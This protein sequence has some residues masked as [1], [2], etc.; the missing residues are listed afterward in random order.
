MGC[1]RRDFTQPCLMPTS[2][3]YGDNF[4]VPTEAPKARSGGTLFQQL[5]GKSLKKGPSTSLGTTGSG[6]SPGR[7][8]M[9]TSSL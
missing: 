8:L 9:P 4:V 7:Y 2:I 5:A 6:C 1:R 3:A